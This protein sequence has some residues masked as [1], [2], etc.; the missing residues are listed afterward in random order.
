MVQALLLIDPIICHAD[1]KGNQ[2]GH[3]EGQVK[4]KGRFER[5]GWSWGSPWRARKEEVD[6]S[7]FLE[8]VSV[9]FRL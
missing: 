8:P 4:G 9:G 2:E 5:R 3:S 1:L 6:F 7:E